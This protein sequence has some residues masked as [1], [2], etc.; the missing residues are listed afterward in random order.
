MVLGHHSHIYGQ[1]QCRQHSSRI[2]CIGFS[3]ITSRGH[4]Y[5]TT[6]AAKQADVNVYRQI[7]ARTDAQVPPRALGSGLLV[8]K[9]TARDL[10]RGT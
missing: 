5:V 10:L 8:A 1:Q 7:Q 9:L 6:L 4:R 3:V 2:A